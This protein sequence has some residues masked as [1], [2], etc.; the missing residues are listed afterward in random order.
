MIQTQV[1]QLASGKPK[2]KAKAL[3][4]NVSPTRASCAQHSLESNTPLICTD[5]SSTCPVRTQHSSEPEALITGSNSHHAS[6]SPTLNQSAVVSSS[7]IAAPA[8]RLI[9]VNSSTSCPPRSSPSSSNL[10]HSRDTRET[11]TA[12]CRHWSQSFHLLGSSCSGICVDTYQCQSLA[13]LSRH[14]RLLQ[15]F[16]PNYSTIAAPLF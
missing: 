12:I 9:F 11:T 13:K 4:F 5:M 1:L 7:S 15:E 3:P 10:P 2:P 16:P 8:G 14:G 6:P